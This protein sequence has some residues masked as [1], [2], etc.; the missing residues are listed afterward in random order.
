MVDQVLWRY[1]GA[2]Q[3]VGEGLG[4][5]EGGVVQKIEKYSGTTLTEHRTE[6]EREKKR[7]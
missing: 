1:S 6:R 5:F 3:D 2:E 7:L 4:V